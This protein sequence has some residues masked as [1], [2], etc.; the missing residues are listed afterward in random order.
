M[1]K[2]ETAIKW[3]G[4]KRSQS[5]AI[6]KNIPK[7]EYNSY[8]EPF[9]GGAS[10]LFQLLHS[11][12]EV[13]KYICSDKN[14]DLI[15]LWNLIKEDTDSIYQHYLQHWNEL[16][17]DEDIERKKAYYYEIR[18]RLNKYHDPKDFMFIMRVTTN[19]MPRYN[20]DGKFNNSLHFT[21][22]GI[23]PER[24]RKILE[25]WSKKLNEKDVS[26]VCEEYSNI[27]TTVD[28]LVYLDPP[29]ANTKGM[30]FGAIDNEKLIEW[31]RNLD[32]TVL[33]SY[34]GKTSKKDNTQEIDF[35][36]KHIYLNSGNSSFSRIFGDNS[37]NLVQES[38][39]V[40]ENY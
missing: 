21:R 17:K 16:N 15:S 5:E 25:E 31:V 4:S 38:L 34:D 37:K 36:D 11:D 19:G 29:Y 32:G 26:F 14:R 3:S 6:I 20:K 28:D 10:V 7:R 35:F 13:R 40:R 24:L 27:I 22:K 18:D 1:V 8:Y 9:C 12:I 39:Y 2:F 23:Q 30:Y 33:M